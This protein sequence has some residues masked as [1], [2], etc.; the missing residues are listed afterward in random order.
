M[1]VAL[2]KLSFPSGIHVSS[3]GFG[4]ESSDMIIRSDTL[5]SAIASV[6]AKMYSPEIARKI[7]D[8]VIISSA[9]PFCDEIL[10]FPKPLNGVG[11]SETKNYKSYKKVKFIDKDILEQFPE[12]DLLKGECIFDMFCS[13]KLRATKNYKKFI[14]QREI[15]RVTI[16]RHTQQSMIFN[17]SEVHFAENAGLFFMAQFADKQIE[18][19]FRSAV[20][21][22]G[23][24][25]IG[26]DRTIGKGW[27]TVQETTI[28]LN[29]KE[30]NNVLLLSL[31]SPTK[32]ELNDIDL[33]SETTGYELIQSGGWSSIG[34]SRY[35]RRKSVRM[36][37]EG[38]VLRF[39]T[40]KPKGNNPIVL[41]K[42]EHSL[43]YDI[44][45]FGKVFTIPI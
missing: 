1:D 31:Y 37:T 19:Q 15:P 30:S 44:I 34:D 12:K 29:D 22:L 43:P 8:T 16:D 10:F 45:R 28:T 13:E 6:A 11:R 25:G 35:L 14:E 3:G 41:D 36:F 18:Q 39:K 40:N 20:R 33:E 7:L 2:F 27:F 5:M 26:A 32:D 24:E 21:L 23:D 42:N 9:F 4:H 38:S 17:F